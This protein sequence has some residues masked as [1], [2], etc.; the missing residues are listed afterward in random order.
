MYKQQLLGGLREIGI[1]RM[2]FV[3]K[4]YFLDSSGGKSFERIKV[5]SSDQKWLGYGDMVLSY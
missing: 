3:H 4:Y 5:D 2:E 1:E